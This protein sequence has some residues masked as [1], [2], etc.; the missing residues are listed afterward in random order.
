MTLESHARDYVTTRAFYGTY[1]VRVNGKPVED[2]HIA[3]D[4][5]DE[6]KLI[7]K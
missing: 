2:I 3:E 4:G 7:V 1:A 6:M 5:L